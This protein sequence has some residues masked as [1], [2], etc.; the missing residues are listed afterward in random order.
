M[1]NK[2]QILKAFRIWLSKKITGLGRSFLNGVTQAKTAAQ[3][4]SVYHQCRK[5]PLSVFIDFSDGD[6]RALRRRFWPSK[7]TL[8]IAAGM[9]QME[10]AVLCGEKVSQFPGKKILK[11]R[12]LITQLEELLNIYDK[13]PKYQQWVKQKIYELTNSK[14]ID[15]AKQQLETW[16]KHIELEEQLLAKAEKKSKTS[17]TSE[18]TFSDLV[19]ET[20]KYIG[21]QIDPNKTTVAQFAGYVKSFKRHI[22]NETNKSRRQQNRRR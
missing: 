11:Y 1:R 18:T 19:I 4:W 14:T 15:G 12:I 20:T 22:Y 17:K 16:K 21:F 7:K 3:F 8:S 6:E 5:T 13:S 9:L 10:F 2:W